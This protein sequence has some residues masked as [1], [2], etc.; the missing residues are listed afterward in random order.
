MSSNVFN[1]LENIDFS[2]LDNLFNTSVSCEINANAG[3]SVPVEHT[4][5]MSLQW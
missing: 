4:Q 1:C 3:S 2:V 5:E